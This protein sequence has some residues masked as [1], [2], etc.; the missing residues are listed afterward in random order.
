MDHLGVDVEAGSSW[1]A[2]GGS[3]RREVTPPSADLRRADKGM[4]K[5]LAELGTTGER[6]GAAY[7]RARAARAAGGLMPEG[8]MHAHAHEVAGSEEA[9]TANEYARAVAGGGG[10]ARD[11][12]SHEELLAWRRG[13][14]SAGA[15]NELEEARDRAVA[16]AERT[17]RMAHAVE[18]RVSQETREAD[19]KGVAA[20][21]S[22]AYH[23]EESWDGVGRAAREIRTISQCLEDT[24]ANR[25]YE[26]TMT[27][28]VW[29]ARAAWEYTRAWPAAHREEGRAAA[30][31]DAEARVAALELDGRREDEL[32]G[33]RLRWLRT[34]DYE[35]MFMHD[36]LRRFRGV[37]SEWD[38]MRRQAWSGDLGVEMPEE[39]PF[40]AE[41]QA[42]LESSEGWQ[43][44]DPQVL[45]DIIACAVQ[46]WDVR[47]VAALLQLHRR[48][49][50]QT[51]FDRREERQRR[52]GRV[53]SPE[54]AMAARSTRWCDRVPLAVWAGK[55]EGGEWQMGLWVDNLE[56]LDDLNDPSQTDPTPERRGE[57]VEMLLRAGAG[58][59]DTLGLALAAQLGPSSDKR[60][61]EIVTEALIRAG[62]DVTARTASGYGAYAIVEAIRTGREEAA[63][64]IGARSL[65]AADGRWRTPGGEW[66]QAST[67]TAAPACMA[68]A[69]GAGIGRMYLATAEACRRRFGG[70]VPMMR[71]IMVEPGTAGA[72]PLDR[73]HAAARDSLG[74]L[75][76][77]ESWRGV[78][79]YIKDAASRTGCSGCDETEEARRILD[80]WRSLRTMPEESGKWVAWNVVLDTAHA[81]RS[82]LA[83]AERAVATWEE[84][85]SRRLPLA[86]YSPKARAMACTFVLVGRRLGEQHRLGEGEWDE[87][88]R[89]KIMPRLMAETG[90]RPRQVRIEE[91]PWHR[92]SAR[93]WDTRTAAVKRYRLAARWGVDVAEMHT[94]G[95]LA[96]EQLTPGTYATPRGQWGV[97]TWAEYGDPMSWGD[98]QDGL[99]GADGQW[100]EYPTRCDGVP[101][102]ELGPDLQLPMPGARDEWTPSPP[103]SPPEGAAPGRAP[104]APKPP[105]PTP[106]ATRPSRTGAAR[107]R[108]ARG[109]AAVLVAVGIMAAAGRAAGGP[110]AA[111]VAEAGG[112]ARWRG[113]GW[114]SGVL[115]GLAA[116]AGCGAAAWGRRRR[117]QAGGAQARG[118]GSASPPPSPP[119]RP[120]NGPRVTESCPGC[121]GRLHMDCIWAACGF[122]TSRYGMCDAVSCGRCGWRCAGFAERGSAGDGFCA[123]GEFDTNGLPPRGFHATCG[124]PEWPCPATPPGS[125]AEGWRLY[126]TCWCPHRGSAVAACRADARMRE[127]CRQRCGL[128]TAL[129]VPRATRV[130]ERD[131]YRAATGSSSTEDGRRVTTVHFE[132]MTEL[133]H[134]LALAGAAAAAEAGQEQRRAQIEGRETLGVR[135]P[136]GRGWGLQ[137]EGP[138]GYHA[139]GEDGGFDWTFRARLDSNSLSGL[140]AERRRA[141]APVVHRP[142]G[143]RESVE[144]QALDAE[145][146]HGAAGLLAMAAARDLEA[147]RADGEGRGAAWRGA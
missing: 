125:E 10:V 123:A 46:T 41:E 87:M 102:T 130:A 107:A 21:G 18:E 19:R 92:R 99:L 84:A 132:H 78:C 76:S 98:Y 15:D 50:G 79:E 33:W 20:A 32:K 26:A 135:T 4:L 5:K 11:G 73:Y 94:Y 118:E 127:Q 119:D 51:Y 71:A 9:A 57:M 138:A 93:A 144:R 134:Q 131:R 114:G 52:G 37:R 17:E 80:G 48:F 72:F 35:N 75:E 53:E 104:P 68:M 47:L 128:A 77:V 1:A 147:G 124:R 60:S 106:T 31:R 30:I 42:A 141:R 111:G 59:G 110:A 69:A 86:A 100:R 66:R 14:D 115:I 137:P 81:L 8:C 113:G 88:W 95:R 101:W 36:R 63:V 133:I 103:T 22:E 89:E 12:D 45:T 56:A 64:E 39:P 90:V 109:A 34:I 96:P 62:T 3:E 6:F 126:E 143:Y 28:I 122:T 24:L 25:D 105:T 85:R 58:G 120:P 70:L 108:A 136:I 54:L 2:W 129:S 83:A 97:G 13:W 145:S 43:T 29:A 116:A 44:S 61:E 65:Q 23:R 40:T 27:A 91:M 16:V 140:V 7:R 82:R 112:A 121:G 139:R 74:E 38:E 67:E 49:S 117:R 146:R 55:E 142:P